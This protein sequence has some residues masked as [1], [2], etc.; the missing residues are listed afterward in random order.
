M[1]GWWR[2]VALVLPLLA[3]GIYTAQ[4]LGW[5]NLGPARAT[6]PGLRYDCP[7]L[8]RGCAFRINQHTYRLESD[9]APRPATL[10]TLTLHG[11]AVQAEAEWRMPDMDM[12]PNR[13]RFEAGSAGVARLRTALPFCS[14][15]RH[16]WLLYLT[17]NNQ[18]VIIRTRSRT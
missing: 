14:A 16:D 2:H 3:L 17:L 1:K 15:S 12:V 9:A 11:P 18:Q 7:D 13:A 4:Y 5:I 6:P 8:A 10:F